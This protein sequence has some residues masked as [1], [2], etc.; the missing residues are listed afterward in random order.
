MK[1]P[2]IM[3]TEKLAIQCA[4]KTCTQIPKE[5][6]R[7]VRIRNTL[8]LQEFFISPALIGEANAHPD[9]T[10]EDFAWK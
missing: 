3:P 8:S 2:V 1:I 5:G 6:V 9:L 7:L 10:A 4:I